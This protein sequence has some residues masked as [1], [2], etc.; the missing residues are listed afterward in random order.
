[1][2]VTSSLAAF[3]L[4]LQGIVRQ[5]AQKPQHRGACAMGCCDSFR[6]EA[7]GW[8]RTAVAG[9]VLEVLGAGA[10]GVVGGRHPAGLI[11]C[12]LR[13]W[14]RPARAAG[15]RAL[16]AQLFCIILVPCEWRS[17]AAG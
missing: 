13:P 12:H 10:A 8:G 2:R 15:K 16:A 1:M 17:A 3:E 5:D 6:A 9:V 7:Q 14:G 11:P 4:Q